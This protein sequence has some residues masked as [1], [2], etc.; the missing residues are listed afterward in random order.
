LCDSE[1]AASMGCGQQTSTDRQQG[2]VL[3]CPGGAS[4]CSAQPGLH[5]HW[6]NLCGSATA[7]PGIPL[8]GQQILRHHPG[9]CYLKGNKLHHPE[10]YQH[11]ASRPSRLGRL[12]TTA[13]LDY[14]NKTKTS[15]F[16]IGSAGEDGQGYWLQLGRW[17]R[18]G[19]G[20]SAPSGHSALA[21]CSWPS[22]Y[23]WISRYDTDHR[24]GLSGVGC[25]GSEHA[26]VHRLVPAA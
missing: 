2:C 6:A 13:L 18:R 16:K 9:G 12:G 7:L 11:E 4:C 26:G 15:G 22:V 20:H 5:G 1:R 3:R 10:R 24:E 17:L 14:G 8:T 23:N 19:S 21:A 25:S